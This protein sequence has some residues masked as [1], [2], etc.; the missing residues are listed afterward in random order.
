MKKELFRIK[1]LFSM[2]TMVVAGATIAFTS[3][4]KKKEI[5]K[6]VDHYD[7]VYVDT[8]HHNQTP[9][10]VSGEI[11]TNTT[12]EDTN[13]YVL[14]GFVYV[15]NG[16]TLTIKAGTVI[17]GDKNSKGTL[18]I[19]KGAK[20]MA[21][22]TATKP[23]VFTSNA[24]KG[25][26]NYGDWGGVI[27]C[28]N[29]KINVA[30]G[31]AQ[32]EGGPRSTYGGTDDN[33]NSGVLKYIRIEYAG[34]PFQ[35]DKEVNGLTL[36][37]VGKGT[38]IDYIQVSYCGDDSFEWFGGCVNVKHIIA[39]KG[40]DDDFDTDFGFTGK[41]QYLVALR[42]K[43]VADPGS[44]SNGFESD[45]DGSGSTNTPITKPIFCN[46]SLFGP[47]KTNTESGVNAN[48]KNLFHL[49]R[50]TSLCLYNSIANGNAFG[51]Q[52]EGTAA[53]GNATS[54]IL[55]MEN[56]TMTGMPTP[57]AFFVTAFDGTYFLD[58]TRHNDTIHK[59]S[60]LMIAD[61]YAASPNFLPLTGSP[62]LGSASF[63]NSNLS[64]PFF[65]VE[66]F[67]GA[68]GTTD[69]TSGW[70]NWDPQNTNY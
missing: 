56:V 68:F 24:A 15:T 62:A 55:Q 34:I 53:Q 17:K 61:A 10:T 44:K 16:A 8:T 63:T 29:A 67:R 45:N 12:W 2:A 9:I 64:D 42:D 51:L 11:T 49:R 23:I 52:I 58:A 66:T 37:G 30:G 13:T 40:W 27:L 5:E 41:L 25:Y 35:P 69:W 60:S 28:G 18:I 59:F 54:N 3:S 22:E 50:N 48:Y 32:I 43:T 1:K 31:S 57:A 6:I 65:T 4:C 39:Y 20:L 33:D 19:E 26:R 46:V 7:T 14:S 70:A 36:G 21:E 38:T 47:Y